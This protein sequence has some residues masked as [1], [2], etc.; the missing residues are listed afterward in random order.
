MR[1]DHIRF[2]LLAALLLARCGTAQDSAATQAAAPAADPPPATERWNLYYQATSIGMYHGTFTSPYSGPLSLRDYPERDVSLTTTIFFGLNLGDSTQF[3]FNP[4]IAGGRGFSSVDG[5]ANA[6]NGELP[7]VA[8]ATPK[9]YIARMFVTHDFGFGD[10]VENVESDANALGG[11]RPINRY[12]V[13]VGRFTVTDYFDNNRY[14]HDPREQF[15]GWAVM[16]NG[17]WDYPADVRGYTWGWVHEYHRKNWSL[18]YASAM[19][20]KVANGSQF[21]RRVLRDR[22]D[23]FEGE[24]RWDI[25]KHDGAIRILSDQQHTYSGTYADALQLAVKDGTTPDITAV[26]KYGTTKYGF[27]ISADQELTKD[28]GVFG[29]LGWN[30]G[31]TASFAFT[32]VDR[33][34]TGGVSV[35]GTRWKRPH[36]TVA[37]EVTICGLSAVHA[38]YLAAG[39]LDFLIGDGALR[40]G[41][42]TVWESYYNARLFPGFFS[43]LDYQYAVNPAYNRDRGPVNIFALRLHLE[44]SKDTFLHKTQP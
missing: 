16:Y 3:Y 36:D 35:T 17:A 33:L 42:E 9:P 10:A 11:T 24:Y 38:E 21:D 13:T 20:P 8:A 18:R 1:F 39:G 37:T 2:G 19:E 5:M 31:K 41:P 26:R 14:S 27:G 28:V 4:E 15:M 32:A 44:L 43:S 29:R 6:A 7:R 30:D 25:N 12:T 23:M 22:G 40:Y 34:A